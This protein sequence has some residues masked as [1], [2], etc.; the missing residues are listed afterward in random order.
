MINPHY[1]LDQAAP[2]AKV[3]ALAD[4]DTI[5]VGAGTRFGRLN[6]Q[7]AKFLDQAGGLWQRG[8]C[9]ARSAAPSRRPRPRV[10]PRVLSGPE[11]SRG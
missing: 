4:Y 8:A 7:M 11:N 5:I 9:T 10:L 3:K 1:K 2:V 6:S